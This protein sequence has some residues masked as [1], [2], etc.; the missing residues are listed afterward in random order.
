M[1]IDWELKKEI[2]KEVILQVYLKLGEIW[3]VREENGGWGAVAGGDRM[4]G[5]V[6]YGGGNAYVFFCGQRREWSGWG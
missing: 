6:K 2:Q 5:S 3:P 4:T 1:N